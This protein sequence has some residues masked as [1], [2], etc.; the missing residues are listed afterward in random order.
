VDRTACCDLPEFPLQLLLRRHPEWRD[1][2]AAVVDSDKPQGVIL[3][4]NERARAFRIL[5]GMR[6]A[7]A[8]S[9]C[10]D[11]H[12]AEVKQDEIER[13]V[14]AVSRQLRRFTPEVEPS[15]GEPGVFWLNASGLERLYGSLNEWVR[16][17][18]AGLERAGFKATVVAGF[19]RFGTYAAAK[20]KRGVIVFKAPADERAAARRVRLDRLSLEPKVRDALGKL[21]VETVGRFVDLPAEGIERRF[22]KVAGGLHR[23]ATGALQPPLQPEKPRP[24]ALQRRI[25]D[26]PESSVPR[27]TVVIEHL[28]Q[29][30]LEVLADRR[31]A[32]TEIH[33]GFRFDRLGDHVECVRPAEPT[34]DA[35]QLLELIRLRLEALRKLPDQV[36]EV[37]LAGRGTPAE[38]KQLQLFIQ[39]SRRDIQA[40]NRALARVRASLGDGSVMRARLREG[41]LPEGSFAWDAVDTLPTPKPRNVDTNKLIRRIYSPPVPLPSRQR[42]EPDG[43]LASD[44]K[45]GPVVRTLGPYIVAGGWWNRPVHREYHYAET[46]RGELLWIFYDRARRRWFLHGRVE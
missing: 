44:L 38:Q 34:L 10:G 29:P 1:R 30:L 11:L 2:P 21:G 5:P 15:T 25:L 26:D 46:Q 43:W 40:A 16:R 39:R 37:V 17:V 27:L 8:L 3:W 45:Q 13:T 28:I 20:A 7:A 41:H 19:G 6:Y 22:G 23:L 4:V 18:R 36:V 35:A 32:L 12:A 9:L 42:H 31:E 33:V 14:V 24:P